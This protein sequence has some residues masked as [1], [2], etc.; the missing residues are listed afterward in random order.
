MVHS[1][2]KSFCHQDKKQYKERIATLNYLA[3]ARTALKDYLSLDKITDCGNLFTK[4][5]KNN[6]LY[7]TLDCIHS[8]NAIA[9][10]HVHYTLLHLHNF[11]LENLICTDLPVNQS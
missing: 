9:T 3:V 1:D 11:A 7:N 6:P 4:P 2:Q 8:V 10:Q 5:S